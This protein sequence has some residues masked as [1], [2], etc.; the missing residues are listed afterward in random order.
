LLAV[1]LTARGAV[2]A[3]R[4]RRRCPHLN[5]EGRQMKMSREPLPPESNYSIL[6][7]GRGGREGREGKE[8]GALALYFSMALG[9]NRSLV[10]STRGFSSAGFSLYISQ[11]TSQPAFSFDFLQTFRPSHA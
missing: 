7:G 9:S 10:G 2:L 1:L 5:K 3:R 4:R 8:P 11:T 6:E